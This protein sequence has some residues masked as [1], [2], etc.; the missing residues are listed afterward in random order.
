MTRRPKSTAENK[1][2]K[3]KNRGPRY[4]SPRLDGEGQIVSVNG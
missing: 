3:T 2:L 4:R 1:L